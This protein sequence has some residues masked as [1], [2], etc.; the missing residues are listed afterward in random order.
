[1]VRIITDSAADFE[2][3]ELEKLNIACVPLKVMIADAE[4]EENVNLGKA[5]FYELLH[6]FLSQPGIAFTREQLLSSVWN[7]DYAGETR[8][9]DMHI[10]TLRQKLGSYG[11]IIETVRN[12]GYRL[13]NNYDK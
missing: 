3:F 2:P 12:V 1:M 10:R 8:T 4:Y 7:T 13:E 11:N 6:L 9:V 5:Q